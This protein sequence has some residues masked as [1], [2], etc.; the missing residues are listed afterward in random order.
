M[1]GLSNSLNG[2]GPSAAAEGVAVCR[3]TGPESGEAEGEHNPPE[4]DSP[5]EDNPR[6]EGSCLVEGNV[7]E[8][9]DCIAAVEEVAP[10][11]EANSPE[12]G[13]EGGGRSTS[14]LTRQLQDREL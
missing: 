7:P 6:E 10:I 2:F 11:A 9:T 12:A 1:T 3:T 8:D 13:E 5:Q 14:I 4:E